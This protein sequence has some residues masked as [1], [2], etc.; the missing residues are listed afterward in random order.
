MDL[1]PRPPSQATGCDRM[2][3]GHGT[4]SPGPESALLPLVALSTLRSPARNGGV[5]GLSGLTQQVRGARSVKSCI[6]RT[7]SRNQ[8]LDSSVLLLTAGRKTKACECVLGFR[9]FPRVQL[10]VISG[11]CSVRL[12]IRC[13]HIGLRLTLEEGDADTRL[14]R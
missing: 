12:C 11:F 8:R 3:L 7:K 2:S 13:R 1:P 6:L 4:S 5:R 10:A 9:R 14:C